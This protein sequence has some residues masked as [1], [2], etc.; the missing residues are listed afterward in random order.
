MTFPLTIIFMFLVFWRPQEWLLP[1]MYGWPV[2]D[3]IVYMALLSLLLE[4]DLGDMRFARTPTIWLSACLW[5]ATILSHAAHTYFQGMLN[6]ATDAFKYC[7]FVVLLVTVIDRPGRLRTVIMIMVGVTMVMAVHCVMQ[8]RLGYGFAGQPPLVNFRP[9]TGEWQVRSLFFG[10]F[11]D[12]ND[13]GQ[14]LACCIPLVFA[15]PKRMHPVAWLGCFGIAWLLFEALLATHSRGGMIAFAA[16]MTTLIFMRMPIRWLPYLAVAGLAA[17]LVL[18]KLKGN[19]FF[20]ASARER[21]VFWGLANQAFKSVPIF[22]LG[23]GMFWQVAGDRAAHNAFVTCYTEVGLLGYFFWFSL[24]QFG[25]IGCW[26][27]IQAVKRPRNPVQVYLKRVSGMSIAAMVG[28]AAGGYFLSRAF[29][30]PIFFLFGI[31]SAI[32]LIAKSYLPEDHPPLQNTATD[33]WGMG[34]LSTFGS[35]VYIYFTIL[36]LNKGFYG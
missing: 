15:I 27:T 23:Y 4:I 33:V 34:T 5:L 10:I 17:G 12:P 28:Y 29:V 7:F 20:D 26:R 25:V 24:L 32:P 9:M 13:A 18:C 2:L 3:G 8:Q 31:L 16:A 21:I 19:A 35:V 22:G 6:A 30:F 1:W 36:I 14:M 11:G